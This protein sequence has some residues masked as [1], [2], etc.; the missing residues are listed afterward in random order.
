MS[1]FFKWVT[2]DAHLEDVAMPQVNVEIPW[3][4]CRILLVFIVGDASV[5]LLAEVIVPKLTVVRQSQETAELALSAI[6]VK[7]LAP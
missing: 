3:E 2:L 7:V 6:L 5:V 4:V 1:V